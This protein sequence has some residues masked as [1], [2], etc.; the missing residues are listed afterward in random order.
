MKGFTMSVNT[1]KPLDPAKLTQ[2]KMMRQ[3]QKFR[4]SIVDE[5]DKRTIDAINLMMDDSNNAHKAHMIHMPMFALTGDSMKS[6]I[7][8]SSVSV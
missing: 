4:R 1:R 5:M 7:C 6:I 2:R 8:A 3:L